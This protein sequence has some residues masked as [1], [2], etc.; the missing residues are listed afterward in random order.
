VSLSHYARCSGSGC[1]TPAVE[2]VADVPLCAEHR[3]RL[4]ATMGHDS[5]VPR[6]V[7][8]VYYLLR[9]DQGSVKIGTSRDVLVRYRQLSNSRTL[10]HLAAVEPG[11]GMVE[12]RRHRQFGSLR[13][14]GTEWFRGAPVL[15]DHVAALVEQYGRPYC[16]CR[17]FL[18]PIGR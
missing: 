4:R 15:L 7:E 5:L 11:S 12:G 6:P 8:V 16:P 3:K 17:S 1:L 10:L 9:P 13:T 18:C 14:P 2:Y